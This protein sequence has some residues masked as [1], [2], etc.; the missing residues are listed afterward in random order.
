VAA[1]SS[2]KPTAAKADSVGP[3]QDPPVE[4][5]DQVAPEPDE[6]ATGGPEDGAGENGKDKVKILN[7]GTTAVTFSTDG[8]QIAA[9]ERLEIDKLDEVGQTA[10]DRG[11]IVKID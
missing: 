5:G 8:R 9:G 4:P 7:P 1:S 11:Y 3:E 10:L 2:R 6:G